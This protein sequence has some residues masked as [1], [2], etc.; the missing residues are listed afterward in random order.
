MGTRLF[1]FLT[2]SFLFRDDLV[3][4][5]FAHTPIDELERELGR[6]REFCIQNESAL[7]AE[8]DSR[9]CNLTLYEAEQVGIRELTQAALYVDQYVLQDP[10]FRFTAKKPESAQTLNRASICPPSNEGELRLGDLAQTLKTMKALT[11]MVAA[12][13]VKFLPT[14][15]AS[16]SPSEIPIYAPDNYFE[17]ALPSEVLR[18][19][20]EAAQVSTVLP[21]KD[22]CFKLQ[23]LRPCRGINIEFKGDI[24]NHA[25]MYTLHHIEEAVLKHGSSNELRVSLTLPDEPPDPAQFRVW[26]QQ[27][28]NQ[29]ARQLFRDTYDGAVVAA[30]LDAAY[31]THSPLRFGALRKA[32]RADTSVPLHTANTFLNLELPFIQEIDISRLMQIRRDEGEAFRNFRLALDHKLSSL[33]ETSD[34]SAA[35]KLAAEAVRELTEVQLHDVELKMRSVREKL[36]Y[37]ALVG[38]VSLAAAVQNHGFS[39]LS[40]AVASVPIGSAVLDYR[41]DV[42][43]HPAFFLWKVFSS[44]SKRRI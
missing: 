29:A 37:S 23:N 44:K 27:S 20:K 26:V 13:F 34:T 25:F 24:E 22:G 41:K 16:E 5:Q 6:Y 17:D 14:S 4:E 38:L 7:A 10:L 35:K 42:R 33:R 32:V 1:D 8:V 9:N 21:S 28:V 18:L 15:L 36:G 11:P 12:G 3:D 2:E 40:A 30:S 43:Q 39:I 19:F 31:S